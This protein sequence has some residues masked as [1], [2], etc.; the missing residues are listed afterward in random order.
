MNF[1]HANI[2]LMLFILCLQP[3]IGQNGFTNK[4][5]AK[6]ETINGL[7]QGKWIEYMNPKFET[8]IQDSAKFYKLSVYK[9]DK[10]SE[11]VHTF[12]Y[13]S[14]KL[15]AEEPYTNGKKNGIAKYYYESGELNFETPYND[16]KS[17]G[18]S[19]RYY[20]SGK[21]NYESVEVDGKRNGIEK[22][23][24]ETG[25]IK[26]EATFTDGK[27]T[28]VVKTYFENGQL[29]QLFPYT[30]GKR[31]G[32]MERHYENGKLKEE[33]P[34]IND[35]L[36]GIYKKYGENGKLVSETSYREDNLN[37]IVK[38]YDENG[39][40]T[41]EGSYTDGKKNQT[42]EEVEDAKLRY[43]MAMEQYEKKDYGKAIDNLNKIVELDSNARVKTSYLQ[44]KC[45]ENFL[46]QNGTE[47][48]YYVACL[49]FIN[50][51]I[52][53]GKDEEKKTELRK[54]KI[55]IEDNQ[56]YQ[57]KKSKVQN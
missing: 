10:V 27:Q 55:T 14:G 46:Y 54:M 23:Y 5:K 17:T 56:D 16:G 18:I 8:I 37:G 32:V 33:V 25:G 43:Q 53:N 41:S 22:F 20:K 45:W 24:F 15:I 1:K 30:D 9:D 6:N 38:T 44:A 12:F 36:T 26:Q 29:D 31:N 57:Q 19:K 2:T 4:D 47:A 49:D 51:Y 39:I 7:K 48:R 34:F 42:E 13:P 40:V 50:Y 35:K 52:K 21:L 11:N 3:L 28:G